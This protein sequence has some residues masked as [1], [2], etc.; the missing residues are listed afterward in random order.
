[1]DGGASVLLPHFLSFH[2]PHMGLNLAWRRGSELSVIFTGKVSPDSDVYL[3]G[4]PL[5]LWEE[6]WHLLHVAGVESMRG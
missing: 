2:S 4:V 3:H 1:M 5:Q 6:R